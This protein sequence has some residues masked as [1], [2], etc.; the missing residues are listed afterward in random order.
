[1]ANESNYETQHLSSEQSLEKVR[2]LLKHFRNAMMITN[3]PTG[4]HSRPMGLQGDV[5]KFDGVLWFFVDRS[6]HKVTE[7]NND[8][9]ISLLFQNDS[10]SAWMHLFGTAQV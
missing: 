3:Q 8:P 9:S 4:I 1:M 6:S 5:E 10:E 2:S 7:I